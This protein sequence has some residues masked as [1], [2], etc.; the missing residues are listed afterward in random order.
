MAAWFTL[1]RLLLAL[2]LVYL[3]DAPVVFQVF[4]F[5]KLTLIDCIIKKQIIKF[6]EQHSTVMENLNDVVVFIA[7]YFLFFWT[8]IIDDEELR[9]Q[10]G[11]L[12]TILIA[13]MAV[14]NIV[15]L[16]LV[17]ARTLYS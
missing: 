9:Y 5:V 6:E 15:T 8:D 4:A 14:A 16:G 1:R 12:Q 7:S 3:A 17:A 13:A 2:V 10:L 11:W